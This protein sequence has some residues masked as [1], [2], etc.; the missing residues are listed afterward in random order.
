MI[1]ER[2]IDYLKRK[3]IAVS[4]FERDLGLGNATLSKAYRTGGAIGTDKL[5]KIVSSCKDLSPFWLVTGEGEMLVSEKKEDETAGASQTIVNASNNTMRGN[6][7]VSAIE[8]VKE[9]ISELR[10]DK[11]RLQ[12]EIDF[13]LARN[14]ELWEMYKS[15]LA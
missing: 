5:E 10:A 4:A 12:R 15:T 13:L 7:N 8:E 1:V 11:E 6:V 14:T 2:I 3:G 9:V